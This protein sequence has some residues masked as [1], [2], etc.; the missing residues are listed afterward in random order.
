MNA[1]SL[2]AIVAAGACLSVAVAPPAALAQA[3][4]VKLPNC[5]QSMIVGPWHAVLN[6]NNYVQQFNGTSFACAITIA[7]DGTITPTNCTLLP[8]MTFIELP[9]GKLTIDRA[10]H[11]TGSISYNTCM[12]STAGGG[13]CG[14]SVQLSISAW[15]SVDGS[16]LT[17]FQQWQCPGQGVACLSNFDLVAGQ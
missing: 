15:R 7:A 12:S 2:L 5:T 1:K 17:G 16:R 10:C 13:A 9:S 11:V 3:Q 8:G 14:V 6:Q 4:G